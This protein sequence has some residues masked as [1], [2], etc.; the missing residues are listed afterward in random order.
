MMS[1]V[2]HI[3]TNCSYWATIGPSGLCPV[4]MLYAVVYSML[5]QHKTFLPC[6]GLANQLISA[7]VII[8]HSMSVT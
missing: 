7:Y 2:L 8:L 3:H 5:Y 4:G 1:W 6:I